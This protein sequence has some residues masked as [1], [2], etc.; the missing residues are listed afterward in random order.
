MS[1]CGGAGACGSRRLASYSVSWVGK[2]RPGGASSRRSRRLIDPSVGESVKDRSHRAR[3]EWPID[4]HSIGRDGR[5]Y[6]RW[7]RKECS[8]AS[9]VGGVGRGDKRRL[10]G[11]DGVGVGAHSDWPVS[12]IEEVDRGDGAD[13]GRA[14]IRSRGSRFRVLS[15]SF[16][17]RVVGGRS[18]CHAEGR[19]SGAEN[20]RKRFN[21][22]RQTRGM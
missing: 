3:D 18:R 12:T 5:I 6:P 1:G 15:C 2:V 8:K 14:R 10:S 19:E 11:V 21:V 13:Q 16:V 20:Q 4:I 9:I 7:A 22:N 17:D